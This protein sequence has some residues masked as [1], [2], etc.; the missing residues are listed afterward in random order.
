[1]ADLAKL[2][3]KL[4][5][6]NAKLHR[7]LERSQKKLTGFQKHTKKS[8]ESLNTLKRAGAIAATAVVGSLAVMANK[9]LDFADKIGKMSQSTG[10]STET[11][12]R[13]DYMAKLTGGSFDEMTKGVKTLQRAMY[14]AERGL[15]TQNDAFD[16]IGVSVTDNT[17]KLKDTEVVMMEVAEQFKNMEDGAKKS[18]LA[19]VLFGRAGLKM[20]P[21]LNMGR[22][23]IK[24]MAEEADALGITMSGKL[25]A[26]AERTNDN[27]TKLRTA[28]EGVFLRVMEQALPMLEGVTK[29]MVAWSKDTENVNGALTFLSTLMKGVASG[30]IIMKAVFEAAGKRIGAVAAAIKLAATGEFSAAGKVISDN[31]KETKEIG[32]DALLS[33]EKVWKDVPAR[34]EQGAKE[35]GKKLASPVVAAEDFVDRSVTK[36]KSKL[37]ELEK[38]YQDAVSGAEKIA[39]DFQ[40]RFDDVTSTQL[41][42]AD[43]GVLDVGLLELQAQQAIDAGDIDQAI[44]KLNT[45]FDI[46]D[47][48]KESGSESSLVIQGMADALKRVADQAAKTKLDQA[49]NKIKLE[50]AEDPALVAMRGT[51]QMQKLLNDSP[52]KQVVELEYKQPDDIETRA[53]QIANTPNPLVNAQ[54][55]SNNAQQQD[56][57]SLGSLTLELKT[58]TERIAGE[59]FGQPV[60]LRNLTDFIRRQTTDA[61]RQVGS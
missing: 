1:M 26:A 58:P 14:D 9:A 44:S 27:L 49:V 12:S 30:A 55:Q 32:K 2:V 22:E 31:F 43:A 33:L 61:A 24:L 11:L 20:I 8:A 56:I 10:L 38:S 48:M 34:V 7:D 6:E 5:A 35:N 29:A 41:Q 21:F 39:A 36:M 59:I 60:F 45:G 42:A 53:Q 23:G 37:K 54:A 46:L 57:P 50:F 18:A 19:Q 47:A 40:K 4:E 28:A 52:L 13:L 15:A 3:V 51:E 17:G 25:T 16:A